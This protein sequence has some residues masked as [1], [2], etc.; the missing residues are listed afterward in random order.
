MRLKRETAGPGLQ[1]V[2]P[3]SG[4]PW[5]EALESNGQS[6]I[7]YVRVP[8]LRFVGHLRVGPASLGGYQHDDH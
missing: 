1:A 5:G 4:M 6:S 2:G 8:G 3:S 7:A